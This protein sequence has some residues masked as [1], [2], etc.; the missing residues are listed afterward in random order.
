MQTIEDLLPNEHILN[1]HAD[2]SLPTWLPPVLSLMV[3]AGDLDHENMPNVMK[4]STFDVFFCNAWDSSGS[5]R[6]NV[7]YLTTVYPRQ[8]VICVINHENEAQV[9]RFV[10]LFRGRFS[11]IDGHLGHTPHLSICNLQKLLIPGGKAMNIYERAETMVELGEMQYWFEHGH[12]KGGFSSLLLTSTMYKKGQG[13]LNDHEKEVMWLQFLT[14]IQTIYNPNG[15]ITYDPNFDL[16]NMSLLE[17]QILLYCLQLSPKM[18]INMK[19]VYAYNTR[20]WRTDPI[21]ELVITK[22]EPVYGYAKIEQC[23]DPQLK[24]RAYYIID[25]IKRDTDNDLPVWSFAKYKTLMA[26][27]SSPKFEAAC[28]AE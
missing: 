23:T 24:E 15:P 20:V 11:L 27:L 9:D 28:V 4:F 3:G 17:L 16:Y 10:E 19:G 14:K 25:A 1:F 18:P 12:F 21:L 5:F 6:R 7:E 13:Y 8:K 26:Y 22:V 2:V